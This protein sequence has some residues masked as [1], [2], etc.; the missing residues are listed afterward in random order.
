MLVYHRPDQPKWGY[1]AK[2][3]EDGRYLVI[4]VWNLAPF[5]GASYRE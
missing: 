3:T 1:D 2:V 4:T 5:F